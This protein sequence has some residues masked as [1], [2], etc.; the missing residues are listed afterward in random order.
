[1]FFIAGAVAL[2][3]GLGDDPAFPPTSAAGGGG[4]KATKNARLHP[5]YLAGAVTLGTPARL[6][7]WLGTN[8]LAEGAVFQ[9]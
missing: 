8:A 4:D 2:G 1:V 7:T 6:A 3:A 5:A 9:A